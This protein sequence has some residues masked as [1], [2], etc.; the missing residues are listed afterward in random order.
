MMEW[1][2]G[3]LT[4]KDI[5]NSPVMSP[6]KKRHQ[7]KRLKDKHKSGTHP[8]CEGVWDRA[9]TLRTP[10]NLFEPPYKGDV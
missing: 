5:Q 4:L 10:P 6:N 2:G 1:V 3:K 9:T 8:T 7:E